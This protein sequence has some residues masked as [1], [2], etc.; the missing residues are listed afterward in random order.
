MIRELRVGDAAAVVVLRRAAL[1]DSPLAFGASV[2]TDFMRTEAGAVEYLAGA[3][4]K[5]L[6][7]AFD[8]LGALVGMAGMLRGRHVKGRHRLGVWGMYVAPTARG[9]GLGAGLL[10]GLVAAALEMGA[11]YIDLSVSSAAPAARRLYERAG[12]VVWG[13]QRDAMRVDGT[14]TDELH[15]TLALG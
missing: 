1:V 13:T 6:I 14:S 15:M 8:G 10:D 11:A 2:E 9:H 12:F 7:G 5:L 3:P 4:E